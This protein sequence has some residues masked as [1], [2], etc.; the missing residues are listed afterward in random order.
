MRAN[1]RIFWSI[2]F[3]IVIALVS[4]GCQARKQATRPADSP[5]E[6][7]IATAFVGSLAS[8]VSA[9][10]QLVAQEDATLTMGATGR[11]ERVNVQAGDRVQAGNILVQLKDDDLERALT[12]A[13]QDLN[14][15][16]ANLAQLT[17]D[18]SAEDLE[19]AQTAV[20]NAQA[21]LDD[22]LADPSDEE[23]E[24]VQ[25]AVAAAQ[26]QLEDLE[27]GPS[28]EELAQANAQLASAQAALRAAQERSEAQKQQLVVAQNDID[29]AQLAKDAARDQYDQLVWRDWKAGVSWGPYSPLGNAFKKAEANYQAAIANYTLTQLQINDSALRQAQYQVSQAQYA[30]AALTDDKT[31]EITAAHAQLARAEA[32][33]EALLEEKA[34]PIASARAQLAQ[35]QANL[36]NLLNGPSEEQ[37]A[38]ANAQVEQA[39]ISVEE[40]QSNL[41]NAALIAPFDGL[42]TDVYL[43]EGELVNGPVAELVNIS[44][45]QVVLDVDEIDVGHIRLRQPALITLESWPDRELQG[46]VVSISPKAKVADQIVTFEVHLDFDAQDLPVLTG[47]TA[48]AE[49]TTIEQEDVLLVPN[50]AIVADRE[51]NAYYVNRLD[52]VEGESL[53]RVEVTIGLRDARY[54][55]IT[56]GLK[57]GDRV[58][59]AQAVDDGLDFTQGPPPGARRGVQ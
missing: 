7:E 54:T 11:V 39:R 33:L 46:Q 53:T 34:V 56:S 25:A 59:T 49:L 12:A 19:A 14:I 43:S 17:K 18:P 38:I 3:V 42:I 35:A 58:S 23:M 1:K 57:E 30:L 52:S 44:S 31:A 51:N 50:W 13:E 22:L 36:T 45:L 40:A 4:A 55:E 32:N 27:A 26:A 24:S 20:A 5:A 29:N 15:Q 2:V 10:G 41:A 9:S 6:S 48:D 47:M 16:L 37:V 28:E 8:E 21:Q